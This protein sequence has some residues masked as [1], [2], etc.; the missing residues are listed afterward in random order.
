MTLAHLLQCAAL[1]ACVVAVTPALADVIQL[2]DGRSFSGTMY[3]EGDHIVIKAEDGT[4]IN[5]KPDE[6]GRVTLT[7][8]ITPAQ[9]A[10]SEWTRT[11]AQIKKA[12]TLAEVIALHEKFLQKWGGDGGPQAATVQKSLNEYRK[13]QQQDGVRFRGRWMPRAQAEVI[14]RQGEE[15]ARPALLSYKA[16][17]I[18]EALDTAQAALKLD[19]ENPTALVVGGLA[20]YRLNNLGLARVQFA[21]LGET[22]PANLLALN[23]AAVVCFQQKR[24][25]EGLLFYTK[26]LGAMPDHRLLLDNII[27]ALNS[28]RGPRDGPP[29]KNLLRQF[30]QAETRM[31]ASMAKK[32]LYRFGSTWVSQEQFDRLTAQRKQIQ[33]AMN[34]LDTRYKAAVAAAASMEQDLRQSSADF[35]ATAADVN[36]LGVMINAGV[37]HGDDVSY[38]A[39]RRE[40]LLI[41][42]D[43]LQ[44]RK[45]ALSDQY[46]KL[47]ATFGQYRVEAERLKTQLA[48]VQVQLYTGIQ[49]MLEPGDVDN[50]PPPTAVTLPPKPVAA[51]A[52]P[53]PG[54]AKMSPAIQASL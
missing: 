8:T 26:A 9:A 13:L 24:E 7:S 3:R 51:P 25:A 5:A 2:K 14:L 15:N 53:G 45:L 43:R 18:K 40:A 17:K 38:L 6:V 23:N 21:K 33:D 34:D 12:E 48:G 16:G 54:G 41:D 35:D 30:D 36:S 4:V 32:D 37:Q 39:S 44:R 1:S 28:Y 29:F 27:E 19:E 42:L 11:A 10:E 52:L 46:A 49:R 31:E 47:T 22:D 20:A 50:P